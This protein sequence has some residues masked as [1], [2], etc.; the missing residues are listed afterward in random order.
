MDL[1]GSH[2]NVSLPVC[3]TTW[4]ACRHEGGLDALVEAEV[5][6]ERLAGLQ[7][8][9]AARGDGWPHNLDQ[10]REFL[11]WDRILQLKGAMQAALKVFSV[12]N[13]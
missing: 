12:G 11:L 3:I 7:A 1:A 2:S 13:A 5:T 8:D 10:V 6:P 9:N 4:L